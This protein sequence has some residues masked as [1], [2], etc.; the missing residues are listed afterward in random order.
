[1]HSHGCQS[2]KKIL[3]RSTIIKVIGAVIKVVTWV[4]HKYPEILLH[5]HSQRKE[6][7]IFLTNL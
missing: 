2:R 4:G 7:G 5:F 1:M 3:L 6:A